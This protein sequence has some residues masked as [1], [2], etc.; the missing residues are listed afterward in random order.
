MIDSPSRPK[1]VGRPG[2]SG[3]GLALEPWDSTV[4]SDPRPLRRGCADTP[5]G[6]LRV[7]WR[8]REIL[9]CGFETPPASDNP[10]PGWGPRAILDSVGAQTWA[11]RWMEG[12]FDPAEGIVL[13]VHGTP[14]QTRVWRALMD[15]PRGTRVSYG[16]LA[17]LL[18]MPRA[19]RAVG[20]ACGANPL[21]LW[22]PCHRVVRADGGLHGYRWG[23]ERKRD[24][25]ASESDF[26][27]E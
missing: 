5:W 11:D 15:I 9:G 18:G 17:A 25:L 21:A 14:F 1:T 8:D 3:P 13:R 27:A 19:A 23:L 4:L 2:L 16:G 26:T 22:I 10:P 7:V 20:A 6:A 12:R 24:L